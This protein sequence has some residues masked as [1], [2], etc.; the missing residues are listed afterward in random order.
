M[1]L[2]IIWV[3]LM[4]TSAYFTDP[5]P[6]HCARSLPLICPFNLGDIVLLENPSCYLWC[7]VSHIG[8]CVCVNACMCVAEYEKTGIVHESHTVAQGTSVIIADIFIVHLYYGALGMCACVSVSL[9]VC[10]NIVCAWP[11][12]S[13]A[14][15]AYSIIQ[16]YFYFRELCIYCLQLNFYQ[17]VLLI[18]TVYNT[19]ALLYCALGAQNKHQQ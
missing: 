16:S 1:W 3:H 18:W 13:Y 14:N 7:C 5:N 10:L 19:V 8:V 9:W 17:C 2:L 11:F 6:L 4:G 12:F 15:T